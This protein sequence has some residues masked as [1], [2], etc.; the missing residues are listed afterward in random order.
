MYLNMIWKD[1]KDFLTVQNQMNKNNSFLLMLVNHME[2][3]SARKQYKYWQDPARIWHKK[4]NY[5]KTESLCFE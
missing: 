5:R 2:M 4:M 1:V 3:N